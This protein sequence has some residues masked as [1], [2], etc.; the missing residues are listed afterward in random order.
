MQ[1]LT[2]GQQ[3][4]GHA[5]AGGAEHRQAEQRGGRGHAES[6]P[7][8][9]K[10]DQGGQHT[11]GHHLEDRACSG[12]EQIPPHLQPHLKEECQHPQ[13]GEPLQGR[14]RGEGQH[15]VA[16]QEAEAEFQ[17]DGGHRPAG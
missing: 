15:R 13:L 2:L 8:R 17:N 5:R 7:Q 12:G 10:G 16:Q 6:K 9:Q 4:Q 11:E 1:G 3:P 14:D